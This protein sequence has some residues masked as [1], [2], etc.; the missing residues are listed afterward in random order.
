MKKNIIVR[1][2][3]I[4][5]GLFVLLLFIWRCP[6][7]YLFGIPCPCCGMTRAFK[8]MARLDFAASFSYH[9]LFLPTGLAIWY[10]FHKDVL[11]ER[12]RLKKKTARILGGVLLFLLLALYIYRVGF[13][14]DG[15][16][17]IDL[18]D[19][20]IFKIMRAIQGG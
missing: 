12:F 17:K 10:I 13:Q 3:V 11:P 7:E 9:P 15:V 19:G 4:I 6:L 20:L 14:P 1:H 2:I 8:S 5:S 18:D 16:V